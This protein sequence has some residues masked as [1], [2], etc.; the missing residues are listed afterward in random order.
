M[1][2]T[3]TN[4]LFRVEYNSHGSWDVCTAMVLIGA[5]YISQSPGMSGYGFLTLGQARLYRDAWVE[6]RSGLGGSK[7]EIRIV[8]SSTIITK[9]VEKV[10]K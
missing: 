1:E 6:R 4:T 10:V 3:Y 9:I 5:E 8:E 2:K 7:I